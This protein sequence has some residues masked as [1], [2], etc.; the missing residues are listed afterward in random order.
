MKKTLS[1]G[2]PAYLSAGLKQLEVQLPST[3]NI[4]L[5][6]TTIPFEEIGVVIL[7]HPQITITHQ[8]LSAL[9]EQNIAVITC[10]KQHLPTG[11]LL[12]LDGHT[13]Q[14]RRFRE[15]LDIS[16][17]TKKQLWQQTVR[18]KILNQARVLIKLNIDA[19]P[20]LKWH[21]AVKSGD[22]DNLEA[23]AAAWYW[24]KLFKDVR[25][26]TFEG[27]EADPDKFIRDRYGDWP[28]CLLNYG[29]AVLRAVIA[30]SLVGSGLLPT[31]G[32]HHRNQ[33]NAY[34]LADDIME[35][36]RPSVDLLVWQILQEYP[37]PP[38]TGKNGE[39]LTPE[40]KKRLLVIPVMDVLMANKQSPLQI[41]AQRTAA[42]L[43]TCF[44]G[45]SRLILYP[46]LY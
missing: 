8:A 27:E 32:I 21:L 46:E 24:P 16:L 41:A 35:P 26:F 14:S 29:Y 5:K 42:S 36:Y 3:D 11:L 12:P 37:D 30:R 38:V 17:P 34:C 40:I 23:R 6:K 13:L 33:Y 28:N 20:L 39:V 25:Y 44:S 10:S 22:P 1:F 4:V 2:N 43:N 15:Q 7:E 9:I 19:K 45:Q 18:Q 31:L